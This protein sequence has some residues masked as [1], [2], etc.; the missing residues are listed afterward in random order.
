LI[1][2][3]LGILSFETYQFIKDFKTQRKLIKVFVKNIL[4]LTFEVEHTT[5]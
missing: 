4:T 5:L 3:N 2:E 1:P